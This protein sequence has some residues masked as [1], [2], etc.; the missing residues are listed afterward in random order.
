VDDMFMKI[1]VPLDG[2]EVAECVLPH[3]EAIAM[4]DASVHVTFLYVVQP[5][6]YPLTDSKYRTHIESEAREAAEDYLDRLQKKLEYNDR[7]QGIVVMDKAADGI[8][9]Y[10]EK[11]KMDLIVMASHGLSG[12][13]KWHRGSVTD[14]VLHESEIPILRIKATAPIKAFYSQGQKMMM[15]VPLDGSESAEVVLD[16]VEDIS[17]QFG[18]ETVDIVLLRVCELFLHPQLHYPPPMSLSWPEYLE[19]ET[20]QCKEIC[21]TYLNKIDERLKSD[22]ITAR[23]E[24]PVGNPI[25]TIV[26]YANKNNA[27][28]L[29]LSTHGHTGFREWLLGNITNKVMKTA[30]TPVLLIRAP[31]KR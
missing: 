10:A 11:N 18:G 12:K 8:I 2:S 4:S 22:G 20:N 9:D 7:T 25:E 3:V 17:K 1:L 5:L 13:S 16:Y 30:L 6:D 24:I 28:L 26:E 15:V 21:S 23:I 27:G 29:V 31:V 19:Y 14:K